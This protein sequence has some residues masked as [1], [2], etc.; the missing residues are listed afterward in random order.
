MVRAAQ[1]PAYVL[2]AVAYRETSL[3]VELWTRD[4]G[5]LSA[6]AK[7]AK[8]PNSALKA[9][10]LSFQPLLVSLSGR[11]EIKTLT[12]AEWVGGHLPP[13]GEG[14][15][16]AYYLNELIMRGLL[17]DDP[18]QGLFESYSRAVAS[19]ATGANPA[20]VVRVF[21]LSFLRELG[22][23]L[24]DSDWPAPVRWRPGEGPLSEEDALLLRPLTRERLSELTGHQS[25]LSRVWMEQ[26][27]K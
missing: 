20:P 13:D 10:L 25:L 9:I 16:S 8:R 12:S 7:G 4:F 3:V 24:A 14:L 5:K 1:Q 17:R 11:A 22:Y 26:L 19:L 27:K 21:E 23:G 2:H 6:V 15:F 18:H